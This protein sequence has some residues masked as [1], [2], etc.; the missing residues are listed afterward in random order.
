VYRS[1]EVKLRV[2]LTPRWRHYS[3][4]PCDTFNTGESQDHSGWSGKGNI[5]C[6]SARN[7]YLSVYL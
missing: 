3:A 1:E 2:F 5:P 4:S 7:Q 6:G